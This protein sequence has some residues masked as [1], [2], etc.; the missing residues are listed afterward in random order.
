MDVRVSDQLSKNGGERRSKDP[1]LHK[2]T[3]IVDN[4][5]TLTVRLRESSAE[6]TKVRAA[7]HVQNQEK[8]V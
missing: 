2:N 6:D 7:K 3:D 1:L 8:I 5:R 4:N